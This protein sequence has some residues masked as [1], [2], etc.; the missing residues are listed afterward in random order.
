MSEE[1][2]VAAL[3][4]VLKSLGVSEKKLASTA[5]VIPNEVRAIRGVVTCDLCKTVTTQYVRMEKFSDGIWRSGA[6]YS[7]E[8]LEK[9][10]TDGLEVCQAKVKSCWACED[11]LMKRDKIELVR[12][13]VALYAPIPSKKDIWKYVAQLRKEEREEFGK[14][15]RKAVKK[16]AG[17]L[18]EE[19]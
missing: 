9:L 4:E 7:C 11:V 2:S 15:K 12:M 10:K 14:K 3:F 18:D 13:V 1:L 17:G 8:E 16:I 5:S 6:D 19:I